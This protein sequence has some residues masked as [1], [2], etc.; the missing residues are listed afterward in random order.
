MKIAI[1][2]PSMSVPGGIERVVSIQANYWSRYLG[3]K[4][5]IFTYLDPLE[6]S[7][8]SLDAAVKII[9][10][11]NFGY[12]ED[13][14]R[15]LLS[16]I[17]SFMPRIK[18]YKK[19]IEKEKPDI[20]LTTMHSSDNYFLHYITGNIPIIGINHITLNL[21]R[22]DYL[23]SSFGRL[24]ARLSYMVLLHNIRHY[25]AVVALSRTDCMKLNELGCRSYYIPN[26]NS[27]A[28]WIT[29]ESHSRKKRAIY[30][31]RLDFLKGQDR[32]MDIW[33]RIV[34]IHKDWILTFVGNGPCLPVLQDKAKKEDLT[35]NIEFILEA[36]DIK[37]LLLESSIFVFTSRTESFG[38][39][40][41][42]A[43]SCG[44]PVISYDCE[45][46][47]RDIICNH[48]NGFLIPNND[49]EQFTQKLSELM[50]NPALREKLGHNAR[51]SIACYDED[52]VMKQ[53]DDLLSIVCR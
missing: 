23:R 46:G 8:F 13:M 6:T 22:G 17:G 28:R 30:V 32:M 37:S 51:R 44:L 39:V 20:I 11:G 27:I 40:L 48:Y 9:N 34:P 33:K 10:V 43:M 49:A 26:P 4:I 15:S 53:W 14:K 25:N 29:P 42:E 3:H 16:R 21:R 31:G 1:I 36:K 2:T 50:E 19:Q 7:F 18:T 5:V 47:P 45:N 24:V 52:I 38:M 12:S 41:I 35:N